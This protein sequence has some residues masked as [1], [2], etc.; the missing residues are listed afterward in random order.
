MVLFF[1]LNEQIV[2]AHH[3][4]LQKILLLDEVIAKRAADE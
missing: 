4:G 1:F 3:A 2:G